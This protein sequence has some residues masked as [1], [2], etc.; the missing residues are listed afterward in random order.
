MPTIPQTLLTILADGQ[1]HSGTA[2]GCTIGCSRTAVWKAIQ[3][4][5]VTGL[6]IYSVRGKGYR[7]VEAIELLNREAILAAM[8]NRDALKNLEIHHEI[9]STNA[10]LLRAAK[11]GNISGH[12]CLAECQRGGRG[13]RGR[14]WVSPLGGNLY[15][16]LVWQFHAGA[17]ALGGLSLAVAVAVVRAL[18]KLGLHTAGLKWPNDIQ[19]EGRKLAGILLELAGEAAGPCT[20]VMGL[21]LNVRTPAAEMSTVAQPWTDLESALGKTVARNALAAG[22]LQHLTKA[23]QQFEAEGLAPFVD[24]WA[25]WDVLTGRNITLDL[26]NGPVHGVARGIDESGALLLASD[27]K[28]QRFHSGE[29]SVRLSAPTAVA[30]RS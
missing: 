28:L 24:E 2:L 13:R 1:F 20:V 19:V 17:T 16:S 6:E 29:V 18:R 26:P 25:N 15:L 5:R 10:Y 12:A 7:L 30:G 22:L 3:A 21:G 9:D 23:M 14:Q 8:N 11:Q 4:L 27:G